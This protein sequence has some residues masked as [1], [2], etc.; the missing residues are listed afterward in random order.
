MANFDIIMAIHAIC[1]LSATTNATTGN[2]IARLMPNE[3]YCRHRSKAMA[4]PTREGL[5]RLCDLL[6][7]ASITAITTKLDLG[8]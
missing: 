6:F 8:G 2:E 1:C 5:R 3:F 4:A 7:S